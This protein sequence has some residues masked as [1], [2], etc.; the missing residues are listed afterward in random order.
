M[1]ESKRLE[2][3]IREQLEQTK[4]FKL[5]LEGRITELNKKILRYEQDKKDLKDSHNKN[6]ISL[7]NET[8]ELKTEIELR[9]N[10]TR[11]LESEYI[12]KNNRLELEVEDLRELNNSLKGD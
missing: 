8:S 3:E 11:Q 10:K 7:K 1:K 9:E 5:N 2:L 12:R 4:G 6:I